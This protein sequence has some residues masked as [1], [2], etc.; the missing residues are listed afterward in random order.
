MRAVDEQIV[1]QEAVGKVR[2]CRGVARAGA[3]VL[4]HQRNLR[5][6]RGHVEC[7]PQRALV[8]VLDDEEAIQAAIRLRRS[9]AVR[10]RVIPVQPGAV[11]DL[12]IV[13]VTVTGRDQDRAVAVIARVDAETMPVRDRRLGEGVVKRD[14]DALAALQNQRRIRVLAP[15]MARGV[16]KRSGD[17]RG[18]RAAGA[19]MRDSSEADRA[20]PTDQDSRIRPVYIAAAHEGC[21]SG[22]GIEGFGSC[23]RAGTD[24]TRGRSETQRGDSLQQPAAGGVGGQRGRG[25]AG[26]NCRSLAAPGAAVEPILNADPGAERRAAASGTAPGPASAGVERVAGPAKVIGAEDAEILVGAV[27]QVV[28]AREE[29]P[30]GRDLPASRRPRRRRSRAPARR[31]QRCSRCRARTAADRDARVTPS[32][33]GPCA[34]SR[35]QPQRVARQPRQPV[36]RSHLDRAVGVGGRIVRAAFARTRS[37]TWRRAG[38]SAR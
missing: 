17:P 25:S 26:R 13:V 23:G 35:A 30:L 27:E 19:A 37:G 8:V 34:Q 38:C 15:A 2:G 6:A 12:E 1:A 14:A 36:A 22:R 10:M 18:R 32:A 20:V 7:C 3:P 9:A 11:A 16:G 24:R 33:N 5:R 28:D 31:D 4:Q 21:R 29:L